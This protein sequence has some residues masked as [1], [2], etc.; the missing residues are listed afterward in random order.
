MKKLLDTGLAMALVTTIGLSVGAAGANDTALASRRV[1]A[2]HDAGRPAQAPWYAY[3]E[4]GHCY[5]W[6]PHAYNYACDPNARY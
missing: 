1:A 4:A 2:S 6:T 5:I 3:D